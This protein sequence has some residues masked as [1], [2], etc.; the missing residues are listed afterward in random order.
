[1][2]IGPPTKFKKLQLRIRKKGWMRK[3]LETE[4]RGVRAGKSRTKIEA[5]W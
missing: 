5:L 4:G 2:G 3:N 1:V